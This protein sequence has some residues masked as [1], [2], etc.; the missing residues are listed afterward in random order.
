MK[1]TLAEI[2]AKHPGVLILCRLG[3]FYELYGED[4]ETC[5]R[6]LGLTITTRG[7]NGTG[8]GLKMA[9]F[10]YHQLNAYLR[11]L[12][13]AGYRVS[14]CEQVDLTKGDIVV[15]ATKSK[16]TIKATPKSKAGEGRRNP[17][18]TAKFIAPNQDSLRRKKP[19]SA[20]P[21]T[22]ESVAHAAKEKAVKKRIP[23]T[24]L[25]KIR[26]SAFLKSRDPQWVPKFGE[27]CFVARKRWMFI[28]TG[29]DKPRRQVAFTLTAAT[30][31]CIV[32]GR[33]IDPDIVMV[34][35]GWSGKQRQVCVSSL[36][37]FNGWPEP[38]PK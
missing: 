20:T 3:D 38:E 35:K 28:Q 1:Q 34:S 12:I 31:T 4:A 17:Q 22:R 6:V 2:R 7:K 8:D 29:H 5:H 14:L 37:P 23:W 30:L 18:S 9:G 36:R 15:T 11:K 16:P 32:V 13:T 10:P 24:M 27:E 26:K 25:D 21:E 19:A 33:T